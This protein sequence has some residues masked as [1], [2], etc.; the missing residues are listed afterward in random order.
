MEVI[1]KR[2]HEHSLKV[3]RLTKSWLFEPLARITRR[4]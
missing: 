4:E 2:R 1:K 3:Q